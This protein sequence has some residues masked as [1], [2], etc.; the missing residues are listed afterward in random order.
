VAL[1]GEVDDAGRA[2]ERRGHRAGAEGVD[3]PRSTELPVQVGVDVD[4]ARHDQKAARVVDLGAGGSRQALAQHSD[5]AV[6]DQDVALELALGGHDPAAFDQRRHVSH[7][8]SIS[9]LN[10][11][12]SGSRGEASARRPAITVCVVASARPQI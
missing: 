10:S 4:R 11:R 5:L 2:P 1:V 3:R 6:L 12:T 8:C 7:P 9:R